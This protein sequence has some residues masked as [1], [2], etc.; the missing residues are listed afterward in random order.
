LA[1]KIGPNPAPRL[2]WDTGK[3]FRSFYEIGGRAGN[4]HSSLIN[5]GAQFVKLDGLPHFFFDARKAFRISDNGVHPVF[6]GSKTV[7]HRQ[8][9]ELN[10]FLH[11]R[12]YARK[13]LRCGH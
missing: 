8:E 3:A 6:V 1:K 5:E 4:A 9:V 2:L 13:A 12:R 11:L 7:G 10:W